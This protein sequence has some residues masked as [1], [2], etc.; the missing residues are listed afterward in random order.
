MAVAAGNAALNI[1]G[2]TAVG[3][4]LRVVI[5]LKCDAVEIVEALKKVRRDMAEVGC[6]ADAIAEAFDHEAVGAKSVMSKVNWTTCDA[7]ER[8]EA[9]NVERSYKRHDVGT[10]VGER[11]DLVGVTK[12]RGTQADQSR[13]P[14]GRKVVTIEMGKAEGGDVRQMDPRS[15]EAPCE[16]ARADAC[17]D[18]Q[19]ARGRAENRSI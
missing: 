16:R 5:A 9:V 1:S 4:H 15:I 11:I 17:V 6:V 10:V 14:V 3:L 2:A 18:K 13:S 8:S 19:D 7:F 12:N